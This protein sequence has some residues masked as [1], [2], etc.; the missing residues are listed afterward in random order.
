MN[1]IQE[2]AGRK[3]LAWLTRNIFIF[4][5]RNSFWL[6][7]TPTGSIKNQLKK[8]KQ[9]AKDNRISLSQEVKR[10]MKDKI[11]HWTSEEAKKGLL[12]EM[13][14]TL[15]WLLNHWENKYFPLFYHNG[16]TA[17]DWSAGINNSR[18]RLRGQTNA[19]PLGG[20]SL[21]PVLAASWDVSQNRTV[22][23]MRHDVEWGMEP[24]LQL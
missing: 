8:K 2:A 14:G 19:F 12:E 24:R 10:G 6:T 7:V 4:N 11:N 13:S 5:Y 18:W 23:L 21:K 20:W 1:L 3:N 9:P 16:K 15:R 17:T 22:R